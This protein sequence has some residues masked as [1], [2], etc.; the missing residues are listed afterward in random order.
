MAKKKT[1]RGKKAITSGR[2]TAAGKSAK[3]KQTHG[4]KAKR[5]GPIKT[6]ARKS[7]GTLTL[8][9]NRKA[10]LNNYAKTKGHKNYKQAGDA[11]F[12]E[13]FGKQTAIS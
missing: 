5:A 1:K 10:Q 12:D 2:G 3:G 11:I 7:T 4:S 6:A 8:T 9:A 13:F